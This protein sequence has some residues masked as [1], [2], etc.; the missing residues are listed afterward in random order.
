MGARMGV[1]P[2]WPGGAPGLGCCTSTVGAHFEPEV[3]SQRGSNQRYEMPRYIVERTFPTGLEIPMNNKGEAACRTVDGVNADLG[4]H[5]VHSY[6]TPDKLRTFCIYD[7]P[8]PEAV[9]TAA[10]R[11][12]LPIDRV[13]EVRVLDP[14]FYA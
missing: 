4:V 14:F 7:G 13:T 1:R 3:R 6:V 12:N 11:N 8:S 2:R 9:R 5:W 10:K